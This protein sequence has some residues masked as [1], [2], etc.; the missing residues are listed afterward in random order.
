MFEYFFFT[1]YLFK[2]G[3]IKLCKITIDYDCEVSGTKNNV[4]KAAKRQMLPKR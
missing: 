4:N 3:N 1:Y 2:A